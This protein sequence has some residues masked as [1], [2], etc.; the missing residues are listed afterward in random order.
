MPFGT[1]SMI[2]KE[3][4]SF[5]CHES[6]FMGLIDQLKKIISTAVS[7]LTFS[8]PKPQGISFT[9][10]F[11]KKAHEWSLSEKDAL[12]VYYHGEER[13]PNMLTRKYNGYELG[14]YY[15]RNKLTGQVYIST[16]WKRQRQ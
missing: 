7:Q 2:M 1:Q 8:S 3:L 14:I 13:K 16:I 6:M 5:P 11:Q 4:T 9:T 10:N 12:D 15:G